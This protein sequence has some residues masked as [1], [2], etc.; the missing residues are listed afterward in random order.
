M[1]AYVCMR[2]HAHPYIYICV[3]ARDGNR[4]RGTQEG[5]R[6]KDLGDLNFDGLVAPGHDDPRLKHSSLVG[7]A[8]KM[9]SDTVY[10]AAANGEFVLTLGGD[11]SVGIGS[12]SGILRAR[13][14]VGIIW[15][16]RNLLVLLLVFLFRICLLVYPA[17]RLPSVSRASHSTHVSFVLVYECMF[18]Q[19][20]CMCRA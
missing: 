17:T 10:K 15:V 18:I 12:M 13:P 14:D 6:L 9:L 11:H 20:M 2:A 7:A 4:G 16:V 3:C 1:H 8:N 19:C 5:W